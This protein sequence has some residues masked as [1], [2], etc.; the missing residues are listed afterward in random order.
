MRDTFQEKVQTHMKQA[1][2][3]KGSEKWCNYHL[4]VAFAYN[5]AKDIVEQLIR[6]HNWKDNIKSM[7]KER[8]VILEDA[9]LEEINRHGVYTLSD[10][11]LEVIARCLGVD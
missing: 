7:T 11:D 9:I 5:N 2:K 6:H 10:E 3:N 8:R 1:E 4:G